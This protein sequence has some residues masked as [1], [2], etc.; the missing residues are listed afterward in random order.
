MYFRYQPLIRYMIF[1]CFLPLCRLPYFVG[2]FLCHAEAEVVLLVY[3]AFVAFAFGVK[4]LIS[5]VKTI[6][7]E[8]TPY[9]FNLGFPVLYSGLPSILS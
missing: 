4:S 5:F 7:K 1:Q 3:L 6:V 2:G 8:L 9:V